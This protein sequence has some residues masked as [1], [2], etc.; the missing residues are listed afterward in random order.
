MATKASSSPAK[1]SS[2][3]VSDTAP[4][5]DKVAR[6]R[7]KAVGLKE[8][9]E[10]RLSPL[11]LKRDLMLPILKDAGIA[12]D[13]DVSSAVMPQNTSAALLNESLTLLKSKAL[14]SYAV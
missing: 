9:Y 11:Q 1:D 14:V 3:G 4:E 8:K 13:F 10:G 12:N 7:A 6:L 5:S 2:G